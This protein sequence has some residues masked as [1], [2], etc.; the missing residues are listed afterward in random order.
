MTEK[1]VENRLL[2]GIRAMGGECFKWVSPGN[3]GV[4]DRII[5]LTGKSW[6]V[7]LKKPKGGKVSK[8]QEWRSRQFLKLGFEIIRL[9]TYE[10]VDMFLALIN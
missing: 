7:E 9:W 4:P 5:M 10:D 2:K 3:N 1:Q 8:V 6:Y